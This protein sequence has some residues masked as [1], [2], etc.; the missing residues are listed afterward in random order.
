MTELSRVFVLDRVGAAI[1]D[2]VVEAR[3][4]ELGPLALRLQIP[5]VRELRCL[6]RLRRVAGPV[7]EAEGELQATVVQTCVVS[8]DDVEQAVQESFSVQFVPAGTEAADDDLEAPDQIPYVDGVID[9]GEAAAEQLALAL[10]PYPHKPDAEA[11]A[12]EP[13]A[14]P[15]PFA[16]LAKL[17]PQ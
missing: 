3:P 10:D 15:H 9:L 7:V 2:Q 11:P 16:A 13:D 12:D 8:L 5:A 1:V 14:V 6:F 4:D 17:R